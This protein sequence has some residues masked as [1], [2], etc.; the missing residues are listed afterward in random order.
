[1]TWDSA[2]E[3]KAAVMMSG[4]IEAETDGIE[5]EV[6]VGCGEAVAVARNRRR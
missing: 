5:V 6:D 2:A 4:G 1:M 3:I